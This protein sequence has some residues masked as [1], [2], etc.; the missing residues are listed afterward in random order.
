M[1]SVT[2]YMVVV[3]STLLA[4]GGVIL[5]LGL[6]QKREDEAAERHDIAAE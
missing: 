3:F 4:V 1:D 6:R 2:L 5:Y